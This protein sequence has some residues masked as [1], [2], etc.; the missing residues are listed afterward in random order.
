MRFT[1]TF[2]IEAENIEKAEELVGTWTVTPGITLYSIVP[3]PEALPPATIPASG[4]VATA[5]A[6]SRMPPPPPPSPSPPIPA[7][8]GATFT[9]LPEPKEE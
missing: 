2:G 6:T 1:V 7:P 4:S 8:G 9:P 3:I 5:L